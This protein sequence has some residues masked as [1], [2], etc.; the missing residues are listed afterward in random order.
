MEGGLCE[1]DDGNCIVPDRAGRSSW[2]HVGSEKGKQPQARSQISMHGS[3]TA[4]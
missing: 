3:D 1:L 4:S 2:V